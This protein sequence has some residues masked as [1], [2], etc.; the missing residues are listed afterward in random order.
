MWAFFQTH[1][2][3]NVHIT[4][5]QFIGIHYKRGTNKNVVLYTEED[6]SGAASLTDFGESYIDV[7]HA[8]D[9]FEDTLDVG[10]VYKKAD[11]LQVNKLLVAY[12]DV[13]SDGK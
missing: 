6:G 5:G 7:N 13:I 8:Q 1:L 2:F 10:T 12:F 11:L 4:K 9:Y 3:T